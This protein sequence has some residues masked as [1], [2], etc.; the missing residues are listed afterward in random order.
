MAA[1]LTG[2]ISENEFFTGHYLAALIEGDMRGTIAEWKKRE[3]E[4]DWKTPWSRLASLSGGFFDLRNRMSRMREEK[5]RVEA[6]RRF[7][8]AFLSALGYVPGLRIRELNDRTTVPVLAEV[9]RPSGEP[10]L[11]CI[12]VCAADEQDFDILSASLSEEQFPESGNER[13]SFHPRL[14]FEELVS[15]HIFARNEPPRWLILAGGSQAVLLDREKWRE[16]RA[17]RFHLDEIF[18]RRETSTLQA[19]SVLLHRESLCPSE[20]DALLDRM[21]A[22]SRRHASNVSDDLRY[23]L[24]EAVEILGNEAVYDIRTRRK[25]ALFGEGDLDAAQLSLECLRYLYRLLFLFYVESR[26]ELGYAP[27]TSEAYR[28]A[29]SLESLR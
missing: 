25:A 16:K 15:R 11:W 2:I 8:E 21:E 5:E 3:A 1:D 6:Q 27:M 14:S 13:P 18:S 23:A 29:Y 20:G 22:E 10:L 28:T 9:T 7:L 17:L 4:T 26:P 24:R 12:D 19:L